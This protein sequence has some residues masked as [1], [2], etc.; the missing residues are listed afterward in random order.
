[1]PL[2]YDPNA[3]RGVPKK[4]VPMLITKMEWVW[5]HRHEIHHLALKANLAGYYKRRIDPYR[6]IYTFEN[7]SDTMVVRLIGTR[8]EIYQ[9]AQRELP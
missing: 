8:D 1:M 3:F 6:I 5:K 9:Q 7:D 2:L 4:D